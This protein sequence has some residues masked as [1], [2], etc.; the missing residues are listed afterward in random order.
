MRPWRNVTAVKLLKY[1]HITYRTIN[2]LYTS[3]NFLLLNA[4][5]CFYHKW[6]IG[7]GPIYIHS[8]C[9][10]NGLN[11]PTLFKYLQ[12]NNNNGQLLII[13]KTVQLQQNPQNTV[14]I[15]QDGLLGYVKFIG[16]SPSMA[17]EKKILTLRLD[18][19]CKQRF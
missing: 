14:T 12:L 5:Q 11:I 10:E 1:K 2:N 16:M 7:F 3:Y 4:V 13:Y 6:S 18:S 8:E 19:T 9:Q 15:G 17:T